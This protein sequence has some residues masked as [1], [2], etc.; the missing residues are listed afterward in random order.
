[1]KAKINYL[2]I[3]LGGIIAIYGQSGENTN[4]YLLICG[5]VLLILGIYRVSRTIPSRFDSDDDT[6][7]LKNDL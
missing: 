4:E 5:M 6:N 1:M 2:L 7:D 3:L